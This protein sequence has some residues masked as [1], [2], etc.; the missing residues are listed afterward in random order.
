MG[1]SSLLSDAQACATDGNAND[2]DV[3]DDDALSL[4]QEVQAHQLHQKQHLDTYADG[5]KTEDRY[6]DGGKTE[7]EQ[8]NSPA[9]AWWRHVHM[10]TGTPV[11]ALGI[12]P[13]TTF[14]DSNATS[15]AAAACKVRACAPLTFHVAVAE[16]NSGISMSRP[17]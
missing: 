8:P 10:T 5:G 11:T 14:H 17:S 6:A 1:T 16:C 2:E 12:A 7:L 9:S 15:I 13:T 3:I 4:L